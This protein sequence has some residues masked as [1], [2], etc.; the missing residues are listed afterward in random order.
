MI[1]VSDFLI[2]KK[3]KQNGDE[4]YILRRRS[5]QTT[6]IG[7]NTL[8]EALAA[9]IYRVE[10]RAALK[11]DELQA[12]LDERQEIVMRVSITAR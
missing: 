12:K 4:I 10:A 9:L 6:A 3:T 11:R 5:N 8:D 7:F 2:S 1:S